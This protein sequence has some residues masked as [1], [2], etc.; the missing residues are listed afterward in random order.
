[1]LQP[2]WPL[3]LCMRLGV[4][5]R[6][7]LIESDH[8]TRML[9][10]ELRKIELRLGTPDEQPTDVEQAEMIAHRIRNLICGLM[11]RDGLT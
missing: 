5:G 1:M 7:A 4:R 9:A 3:W 8:E 11:L 10:A 6:L 2:D